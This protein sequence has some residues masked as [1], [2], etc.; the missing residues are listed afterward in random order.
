[1]YLGP[2]TFMNVAEHMQP[3]ANARDCGEQIAAAGELASNVAV[4][5]AERRPVRDQHSGVVWDQ[6]PTRG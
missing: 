5:D 1:M 6:R 2:R 4:A 3:G